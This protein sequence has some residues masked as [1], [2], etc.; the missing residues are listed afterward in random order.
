MWIRHMEARGQTRHQL[1]SAT[2]ESAAGEDTFPIS[3][4]SIRRPVD[5]KGL[6]ILEIDL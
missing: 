1:L 2:R 4:H 6:E 3:L 5:V